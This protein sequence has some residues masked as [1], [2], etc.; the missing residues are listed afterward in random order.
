MHTHTGYRH[1]SPALVT[2]VSLLVIAGI[3]LFIRVGLPYDRVLVDGLVWFKGMDA[4]YHMR[5]VDNLVQNF[6]YLTSFDPYTCYPD[7]NS[8]LFHPLTDWLVAG[9]ARLAGTGSPSQHM[10]DMVGA[11]LPPILGTLIIFP[12]YFIGKALFN[13]WVGLLSAA[14]VVLLPGELLNRSLLGFTDHHV[15]E[16]L[17]SA[18][19]IL[20][21]MLAIRSARE[22]NL[23]FSEVQKRDWH[24]I[25]TP[26]IYTALAG[27][28]LG[29]YL[30]AWRGGLMLVFVISAYLAVQFVA[31]HLA[32]RS[33]EY[34]CVVGVLTLF[35]GSVVLLPIIDRA[36]MKDL[37][38][39]SLVIATLA[40]AALAGV[41]LLMANKGIKRIYYPLGLA[42]LVVIAL[43]LLHVA[44]PSLL[45]S[46]LARFDIFAPS[47][48]AL[49]I[50]ET[51]PLLFPYGDFSLQIAWFNFSTSFFISLVSFGLIIR[52]SIK[53]Q[54]PDRILFL[55]W[56]AIM[57]LAVLGQRRFGYYYTINAALLTGYFSWRVLAFA[58]ARHAV[59]SLRGSVVTTKKGKKKAEV[60][61]RER[62]VRQRRAFLGR[63][64]IAAVAVF[65]VAFFPNIGQARTVATQSPFITEG[66]YS[67]LVWL[68]DNSPE[69]L[70]HAGSYYELHD[71]SFEYPESAYGIMSWWDYGHWITRIAHRIPISN[72]FQYG[73]PLAARY[74]IAQDEDSA[75]QIMN[76]LDARYVIVDHKMPTTKFHAMPAFADSAGDAFY[77]TY[78][79]PTEEGMLEPVRLY[80]PAYYQSM[81]VRLYVFDGEA[82]AARDPT[83]VSYEERI[84]KEGVKYKRITNSQSFPT[85]EAAADYLDSLESGDCVLVSMDSFS[86]PVALEA[87]E[88]YQ[89]ICESHAKTTVAGKKR[90]P[91]V[92]IFEY[93]EVE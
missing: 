82:V 27:T 11:F 41:S 21:L 53:D 50:Q 61:M 63:A 57:L 76:D 40:P 38:R 19:A 22:R 3:S 77:E 66:W 4:W 85:Y 2:V 83:V 16:S 51:H 18:V 39:A 93:V 20:F 92:K 72:P 26:L 73:A 25:A 35:I 68:K 56:S 13:R 81:V 74:F 5:L 47:G 31:D 15:A 89:L 54:R 71:A 52:L 28:F 9:T 48:T 36:G 91:E 12:V 23:T 34:L 78:H 10:V 8:A 60:K 84:S 44:A 46:M 64:A 45:H 59:A 70:G 17:F 80:Y 42:A 30:L 65:F 58:G 24:M 43:A 62:E 86:S 90:L 32:G 37:Y 6:P 29:I 1:P 7:G 75:N 49:T 87:L 14:L 88:Q 33:T 67:S 55:V 79:R 69:P